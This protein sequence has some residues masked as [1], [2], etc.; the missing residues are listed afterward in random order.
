[1][2]M[3]KTQQELNRELDNACAALRQKMLRVEPTDTESA[4]NLMSK[5]NS[6]SDKENKEIQMKATS[7]RRGFCF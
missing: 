1:M 5:H 4:W 2:K 3:Q 6:R 7:L